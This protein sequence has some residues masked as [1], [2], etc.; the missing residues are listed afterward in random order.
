MNIASAIY[1]L[2]ISQD[3]LVPFQNYCRLKRIRHECQ[4]HIQRFGSDLKLK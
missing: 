2:D 4:F 3:P 1:D